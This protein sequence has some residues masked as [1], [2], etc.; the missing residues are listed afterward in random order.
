MLYKTTKQIADELGVSK[1]QVYRYIKRHNIKEA[2]QENGVMYYDDAAEYLIT[3]GFSEKS[4]SNETE[5]KHVNDTALETV[6]L[7]LQKELEAKN[8]QL[9]A[10]DRQIEQLTSA[11]EN[12]TSSLQAA[13]ALH[14]GT[15]QQ[16]LEAPKAKE[17]RRWFSRRQKGENNG[18]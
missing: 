1:Q 8:E 16:Q 15:L 4:K 11:L 3:Q 14:A 7:M 18:A 2:H 10:K 5:Q 12:T 6:I 17:E 9:Q 13:Q